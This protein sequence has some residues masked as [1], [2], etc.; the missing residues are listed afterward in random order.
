MQHT[1]AG[2]VWANAGIIDW[3]ITTERCSF[4]GLC[5]FHLRQV[6]IDEK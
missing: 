2:V 6:H 4:M 1:A 3:S 5:A